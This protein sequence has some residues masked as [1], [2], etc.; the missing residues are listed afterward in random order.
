MHPIDGIVEFNKER[1][2]ETFKGL[3]EYKMLVEELQEF[4][5]ACSESDTH[6]MLNALC[7]LIVL[8]T[9]AIYKLGYD[10]TKVLDETVKEIRSRQGS[11]DETTGKWQKD[12]NQDASTLYVPNYENARR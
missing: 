9:G 12:K 5:V 3:A 1:R 2:L 4:L 8:S 10:P 11:F 6:E 7:D